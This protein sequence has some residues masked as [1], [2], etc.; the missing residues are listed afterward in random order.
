MSALE[1]LTEAYAAAKA[2]PGFQAELRRA[3]HRLRRAG[4]RC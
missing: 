2:D 3:A 1:E 4:R